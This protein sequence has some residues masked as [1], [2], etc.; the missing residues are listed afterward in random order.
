MT[1]ALLLFLPALATAFVLGNCRPTSRQPLDRT[2]F[3]NEIGAAVVERLLEETQERYAGHEMYADR[4]NVPY[5]LV[6]GGAMKAAS[7][8]FLQRFRSRGYAFLEPDDLDYDRVTNATVIKG[9]RTNP[10]VLQLVK[11]T[12]LGP[13]KHEMVAAWNLNKEVVRK[14]YHVLGDPDSGPLDL[15]E[16]ETKAKR[17]EDAPES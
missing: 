7:P 12:Q 11:L 3:E 9:S 6:I 17:D 14:V 13:E 15:I 5:A 16:V 8:A 1:R 10:V 2:G 4:E